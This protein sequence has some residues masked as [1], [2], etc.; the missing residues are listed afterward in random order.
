MT[1]IL[2][3]SDNQ[4]GVSPE[5]MVAMQR[6]DEGIAIA[7]G[8]DS[9]SARL[10]AA[11]SEIFE[12]DAFVFSATTGSAANALGL[13]AITPPYGE[14]ICHE[15]AHILTTE[16]GAPEFYAGGSRLVGMAGRDGQIAADDLRALLD[17]RMRPSRHHYACSSLSLTQA[18]EFGTLYTIAELKALAEIAHAK[19][20]RVHMDGARFTNAL[21]ALEA[22][23]AAMSWRAGIDVLSLGTTKNGTMNAEAVIVFDRVLA[24]DL[25]HRQKRAGLLT[26][27]MRYVSAQLLAFLDGDLWLRNARQANEVTK[28]VADILQRVPG[29]RLNH[30]VE[31]NQIFADIAPAVT[32]LLEKSGFRFRAW[33]HRHPTRHRLVMSFQDDERKIERVRAALDPAIAPLPA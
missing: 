10:D 30:P 7:Y 14:T 3:G 13:A 31:T 18:T 32:A 9:Y 25:A 24:R 17:E 22:S 21:V 26:S 1:E 28:A 23:P 33:D 29:I 27:K 12:H 11:F 6:A 8:D 2:F 4:A 15:A 16:G 20:L 19:G 5:I